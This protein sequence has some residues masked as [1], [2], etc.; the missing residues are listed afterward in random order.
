M[1]KILITP[2]SLTK[3]G[4]PDLARL[5]AAGYELV[6]SSPGKQPG[7]EELLR[8]VPGCVGWLAGVETI[9]ARV[10]EAAK[11]L[12]AISRNGTGIDNID[13][14]AA[15]RLGIRILRAEGANA[16]GV[17]E[18]AIGLVFALARSIPFSDRVLKSG[19]W[20]RRKGMELLGKRLGVVGCGRI[21]RLVAE[22]ALGLGMDVLGYDVMPDARFR[23]P[24]RF[25]FTSLDELLSASHVV[26]LH[27]P[28]LP[29]GRPLIDAGAL[30]R[31]RKGALLVNT[32]RY[33]LI[34]A[35][36]LTAALASGHVAGAAIDVFDR[37]P[38][39]GNPL[40]T[41]DRVIATPHIG[42]FTEESVDRAV[43]VAVTNLLESL[44]E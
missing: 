37:E 5:T 43:G 28:P 19:E 3:D 6:L 4:H 27:C 2:R 22:I 39:T 33:D 16:R 24:E 13:R 12:R 20:E 9:S 36:A 34:D 26:T 14:A 7:E 35:E 8:L 10:L 40:V 21:G 32:A 11:G 42:G 15:E 17:A 25:R 1:A 30:A 41:S 29:D 44:R 31:M 18:L 38:P 23:P